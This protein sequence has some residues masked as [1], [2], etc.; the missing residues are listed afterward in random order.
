MARLLAD[1]QGQPYAHLRYFKKAS[2]AAWMVLSDARPWDC[3][4]P[5]LACSGG[6]A[7]QALV[8]PTPPP[9]IVI[10]PTA[11]ST[12]NDD[13]SHLPQS[14]L[15][16]HTTATLAWATPPSAGPRLTRSRAQSATVPCLQTA[17]HRAP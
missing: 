8:T 7:S 5:P 1:R 3:C 10:T 2:E 12:L 15:Q 14:L 16:V 6:D 9:L 17:E 11:S 4:S 13:R